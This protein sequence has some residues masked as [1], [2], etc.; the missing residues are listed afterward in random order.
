MGKINGKI[1]NPASILG[2]VISEIETP[3]SLNVSTDMNYQASSL[4]TFLKTESALFLPTDLS[5][6]DNIFLLPKPNKNGQSIFRNL[7]TEKTILLNLKG[8]TSDDVKLTTY[9]YTI[10]PNCSKCVDCDL[11]YSY[12]DEN[13]DTITGSTTLGNEITVCSTIVPSIIGGSCDSN[14][15][16]VTNICETTTPSITENNQILYIDGG[17]KYQLLSSRSESKNYGWEPVSN[18]AKY[19]HVERS[20]FDSFDFPQVTIRGVRKIPATTADTLCGPVKYTGETYDRMNYNWFFG[21]NAGI[22]FNPIQSGGTP[23][24]LS[25]AMVSQ[26]G[27]ASISNREGQLLFYTNGETVYTSGNTVMVNGTGLSTSGTSTQSSVI[28]PKPNSNKYYIFTTD[29]NGSPN[30]FEYSIVNMELQDGDG[31]V[32]AKNIKL[33]NSPLTEK[34]TAC[35]HSDGES[36]W[37]VTHTSGD[38]NYYSYRLSSSGLIGPV[39]TS[40]GSTHNSSR[41]YMKTSLDCKKLISL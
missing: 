23:V 7:L 19:N 20:D 32:E 6:I 35:S 13:G 27:V 37:I 10:S 38:T 4:S 11:I 40:I 1:V 31:E 2:D 17:R 14:A 9:E 30:G 3:V 5:R 28:V 21:S 41:G 24:I 36:Y 16:K 34:V 33:I 12:I 25:G 22:S 15:V 18:R 26:E 39:T 29:Y 8:N